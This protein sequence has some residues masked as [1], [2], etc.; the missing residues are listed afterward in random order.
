MD[1]TSEETKADLQTQ[2]QPQHMGLQINRL[3]KIRNGGIATEVPINKADE[4]KLKLQQGFETRQPKANKPNFKVLDVPSNLDKGQF[5]QSVYEQNFPNLINIEEFTEHFN[6][7]FRTGPR[8]ESVTQW[9]VEI[10]K[11]V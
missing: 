2:L 1:Q 11:T 5:S 9:I 4:L 6:L 7:L 10:G 8:D 3:S